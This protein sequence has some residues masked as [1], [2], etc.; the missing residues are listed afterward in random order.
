MFQ[1]VKNMFGLRLRSY[2]EL[3]KISHEEM[4]KEM[5]IKYGNKVS[6][7]RISFNPL[8]DKSIMINLYG[9]FK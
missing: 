8:T 9:E 6:W 2:E 5:N 7:Y 1:G 4:I 3:I